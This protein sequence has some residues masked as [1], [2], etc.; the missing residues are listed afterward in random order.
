[1]SEFE[2]IAVPA[3]TADACCADGVGRGVSEP[4][5][6]V[7]HIALALSACIGSTICGLEVCLIICLTLTIFC[8][9]Y[10]LYVHRI[11]LRIRLNYGS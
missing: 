10:L 7:V 3:L 11:P 5:A 4:D 8:V 6:S 9:V 2:E 1:M